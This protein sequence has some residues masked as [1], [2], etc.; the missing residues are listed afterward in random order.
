[1]NGHKKNQ[2]A[3]EWKVITKD[4][5]NK[6]FLENLKYFDKDHVSEANFFLY[7]KYAAAGDFTS[8]TICSKSKASASMLKWVEALYVYKQLYDANPDKRPE[9]LE[10]SLP[11]SASVSPTKSTKKTKKKVIEEVKEPQQQSDWK[12]PL[13][14]LETDEEKLAFLANAHA[15]LKLSDI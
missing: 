12:D 13:N 15:Q 6:Q 2:A 7:K 11:K 4:L 1:M 10:R 5:A 14:D 9:P 3:P 8:E